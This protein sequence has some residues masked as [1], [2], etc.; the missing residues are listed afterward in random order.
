MSRTVGSL[1]QK[2]LANLIVERRKAAKL[3]QSDVA[4]RLKRYQ[5]FVAT[6]ES[7]QRRI[8]VIEFMELAD[9]IGFDPVEVIRL[10]KK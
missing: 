9:I 2:R 3:T 5:S 1:R 7:G 10:L 4:R 8:D 6:L